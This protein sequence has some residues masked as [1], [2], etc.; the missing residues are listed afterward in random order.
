MRSLTAMPSPD[1]IQAVGIR[2]R[3]TRKPKRSCKLPRNTSC[4][5]F[6][7]ADW[8]YQPLESC[9]SQWFLRMSLPPVSRV[10]EFWMFKIW[11]YVGA[12]KFTIWIS[13][14]PGH[15][16]LCGQ[17]LKTPCRRGSGIR[18]ASWRKSDSCIPRPTR[19]T[20]HLITQ[21][22]HLCT[23]A[24]ARQFNTMNDCLGVFD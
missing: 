19:P 10:A 13:R 17:F 8:F 22:S 11:L 2:Y 14:H 23:P 16:F 24:A 18:F 6:P 3:L 21:P 1:P 4:E 9:G 15:D 7:A 12:L 5:L 20:G